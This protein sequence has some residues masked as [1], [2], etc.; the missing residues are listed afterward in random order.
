[1]TAAFGLTNYPGWQD[2]YEV[3]LYSLGWRLGGKGAS[4]RNKDVA[5]RI[6]EHGLHVWMGHYENAFRVMRQVYRELGRPRDAP[7]ADGGRGLQEAVAHHRSS[8]V[9]PPGGWTG[10]SRSPPTRE[11]PG[12]G[13]G[14]RASYAR[15]LSGAGL[16]ALLELL[17]EAPAAGFAAATPAPDSLPAR[18]EGVL[19]ALGLSMFPRIGVPGIGRMLQLAQLLAARLPRCPGS[20]SGQLE[21]LLWLL[22]EV[23][24]RLSVPLHPEPGEQRRPQGLGGA[25]A[26]ARRRARGGP[27]WSAAHGFNAIDGE[28]FRAWLARHGAS[29]FT[30]YRAPIV[31]GDVP[32]AVRVPSRAIRTGSSSRRAWPRGS[33]CAWR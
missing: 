11:E 32:A 31:K 20:R 3:S 29:D 6:E 4:G 15:Y 16:Q 17:N 33:C 10:T 9:F 24:A 22:E 13:R 12:T 5:Q 30:L 28:D 27:G 1:M 26:G 8:S 19:R 7:L 2:H 14:R 21:A 25:G 18:V 23:L